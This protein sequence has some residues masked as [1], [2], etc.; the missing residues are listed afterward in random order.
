MTKI[1][2][3]AAWFSIFS[4]SAIFLLVLCW[5]AYP[6]DPVTINV[7]PLPVEYHEVKAGESIAYTVD[8]CRHT[9]KVVHVATLLVGGVQI[10]YPETVAAD[11]VGCAKRI[12]SKIIPEYIPA[13]EYH[14]HLAYTFQMNPIRSVTVLAETD[15]FKVVK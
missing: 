10:S 11:N 7:L 9:D 3:I 12:F 14:L 15:T 5:L 1:F 13:G 6:Y 2:R 4:A 8:R